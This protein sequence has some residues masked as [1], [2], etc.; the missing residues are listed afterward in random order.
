M[1]ITWYI[2]QPLV[3]YAA[4]NQSVSMISFAQV[5]TVQWSNTIPSWNVQLLVRI[6]LTWFCF[7]TPTQ[8]NYSKITWLLTS[9]VPLDDWQGL[10]GQICWIVNLSNM[11]RF[12][13]LIFILFL[14][15]VMSNI[16]M[17]GLMFNCWIYCEEN[18]SKTLSIVELV[19]QWDTLFLSCG[20][21]GTYTRYSVYRHCML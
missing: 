18:H 11:K 3:M 16:D 17:F 5:H 6:H 9:T 15:I 12:Y 20:S 10:G 7:N 4:V 19:F 2:I 1:S 13:D 8:P 14:N 21:A